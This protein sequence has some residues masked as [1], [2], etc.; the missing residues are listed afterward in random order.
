[1]RRDATSAPGRGGVFLVLALVYVALVFCLSHVPGEVL[2]LPFKV[3]D[4]AIHFVEYV[5]LGFLLVGW[6]FRRGEDRRL[7]VALIATLLVV[8]LGTLDEFHQWFVPGRSA[9]LGDTLADVAGG[10][11][12]AVI[13]V[14]ALWARGAGRR[15]SRSR[16]RTT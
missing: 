16:S 13:G 5:P 11:L 8:V 12:G 1:M 10:L 2:R 7:R 15:V 6:Q 14:L 4:K 9:T 3:W